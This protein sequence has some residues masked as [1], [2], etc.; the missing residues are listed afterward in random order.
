MTPIMKGKHKYL[1]LIIH[2]LIFSVLFNSL[3]LLTNFKENWEQECRQDQVMSFIN[4]EKCIDCPV[5]NNKPLDKFGGGACAYSNNYTDNNMITLTSNPEDCI[6]GDAAI[7]HPQNF[8]IKEVDIC[9]NL[10]KCYYCLSNP[11]DDK[12]SK[13]LGNFAKIT[14]P[15]QKINDLTIYLPSV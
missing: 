3:L 7:P 14:I 5:I 2:A 9:G 8:R 15:N 12:N 11:P 6:N 13:K 1:R 10:I 4:R